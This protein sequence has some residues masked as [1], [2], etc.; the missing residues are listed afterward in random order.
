MKSLE[1]ALAAVPRIEKF[2]I[3]VDK[4]NKI[5]AASLDEE[6][7]ITLCKSFDGKRSQYRMFETSVTNI[8]MF[9]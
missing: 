1:D 3:V 7:M 5:I 4:K 6:L 9:S 8:H 2:Y